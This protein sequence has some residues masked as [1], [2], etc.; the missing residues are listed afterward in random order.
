MNFS[1]GYKNES[2]GLW[3]WLWIDISGMA[4][5]SVQLRTAEDLSSDLKLSQKR[6]FVTFNKNL[7]S[8]SNHFNL[9][10]FKK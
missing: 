10:V 1:L 7:V 5:S 4:K 9:K 2:E 6:C 8:F 3:T